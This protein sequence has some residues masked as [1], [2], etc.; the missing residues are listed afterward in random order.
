MDVTEH[1]RSTAPWTEHR[2]PAGG[3]A[4]TFRPW[5]HHGQERFFTDNQEHN[6][7]H[8]RYILGSE[9][10]A[11]KYSRC[12]FDGLDFYAQQFMIPRR[13]ANHRPSI[14]AGFLD[15]AEGF[16]LAVNVAE[17]SYYRYLKMKY[18]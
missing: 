3:G 13:F 2:T 1:I 5:A 9:H 10:Y 12:R 8:E 7:V 14:W 11:G 4:L 18:K 17:I 15:G 16:I 6:T